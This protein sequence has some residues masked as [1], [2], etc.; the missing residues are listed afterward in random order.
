[1]LLFQEQVHNT[2]VDRET[3]K[4]KKIA[5][6]SSSVEQTN[7]LTY[8]ITLESINLPSSPK[9]IKYNL[10]LFVYCSDISDSWIR[11]MIRLTVEVVASY[12]CCPSEKFHQIL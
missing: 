6:T 9:P 3:E 5:E 4:I 8:R 7:V 11:I 1:M 12:T 10:A 2:E